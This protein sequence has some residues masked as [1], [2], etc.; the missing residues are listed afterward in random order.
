M[1]ISVSTLLLLTIARLHVSIATYNVERELQLQPRR[2]DHPNGYFC[3][4]GN[5]VILAGGERDEIVCGGNNGQCCS[6]APD[7]NSGHCLN[8]YIVHGCPC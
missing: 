5:L 2:S 7:H 8:C 4:A 6:V 3:E 1:Y